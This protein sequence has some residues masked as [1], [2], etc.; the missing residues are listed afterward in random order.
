MYVY[1]L[2]PE[3]NNKLTESKYVSNKQEIYLFINYLFLPS[4]IVIHVI[5]QVQITCTH[6][7]GAVMY[8]FITTNRRPSLYIHCI[9]Q[10]QE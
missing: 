5:Y 6:R 4:N 9:G 2:K 8:S 10:A 7:N 3:H 1:A